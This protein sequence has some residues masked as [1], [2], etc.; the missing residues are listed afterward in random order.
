MDG[1]KTTS[2]WEGKV[3]GAML[4]FGGVLGFKFKECEASPFSSSDSKSPEFVS[5]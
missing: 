2:Y 1:W 4:N 3:S 5:S